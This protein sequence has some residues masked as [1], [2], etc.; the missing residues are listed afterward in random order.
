VVWDGRDAEGR[1]L[2]SGAFVCRLSAAG[3]VSAARLTLVR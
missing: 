3:A 1:A 2:A